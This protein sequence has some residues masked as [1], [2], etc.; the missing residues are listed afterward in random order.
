VLKDGKTCC[1]DYALMLSDFVDPYVTAA[2]SY[3]SLTTFDPD[4]NM[5]VYR[6]GG[7]QL[8]EVARSTLDRLQPAVQ[9]IARTVAADGIDPHWLDPDSHSWFGYSGLVAPARRLQG[10]LQHVEKLEAALR[11]EALV[12]DAAGLHPWA[13]EPASK[14]WSG[15][16][17]RSAVQAAT[18]QVDIHLQTK[19]DRYDVSGTELAKQA[20]SLDPPQVGKPRLRFHEVVKGSEN[21]TSKH[22]GAGQLGQGIS[23]VIRNLASHMTIELD[24]AVA[25]EQLACVSFWARLIDESVVDASV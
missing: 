10:H 20:F 18:T 2:E 15:G 17:Y 22:V 8:I 21:Y 1:M 6:E 16:H 3:A 7:G 13:W 14:L 4:E 11:S 19:L 23:K 25:L 12:V 9:R 24:A 5:V